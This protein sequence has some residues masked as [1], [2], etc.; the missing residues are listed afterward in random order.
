MTMLGLVYN[1]ILKIIITKL[2][3]IKSISSD[4]VILSTNGNHLLGHLFL[5]YTFLKLNN[6]ENLP[7]VRWTWYGSISGQL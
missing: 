6:N 7:F 2:T 5:W 1:I 4:G 3:V